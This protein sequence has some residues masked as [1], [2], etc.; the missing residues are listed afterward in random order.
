M[1]ASVLPLLLHMLARLGELEE[2][3]E[4][5]EMGVPRD[6]RSKPPSVK[7]PGGDGTEPSLQQPGECRKQ[8]MVMKMQCN[9]K[10]LC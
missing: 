10:L 9:G 5:G 6:R 8:L 3:G 7:D 4:S 1:A 2:R